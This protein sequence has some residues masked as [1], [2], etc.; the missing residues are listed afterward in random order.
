MT[1]TTMACYVWGGVILFQVGIAFWLDSFL[2]LFAF[3]TGVLIGV[4]AAFDVSKSQ[5]LDAK[6]KKKGEEEGEQRMTNETKKHIVELHKTHGPNYIVFL[7]DY[8]YNIDEINSVLRQHISQLEEER[9]ALAA[10]LE[11]GGNK[12]EG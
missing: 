10:A 1:H 5:R 9:D 11:N 7:L 4:L 6:E 2:P 8:K 3:L 12:N